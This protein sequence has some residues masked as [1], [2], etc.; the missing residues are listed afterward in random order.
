MKVYFAASECAP[1][2][3][4]GGLAD[5]VGGLP[6]A[7]A[8]LG[9]DTAIMLPKYESIKVI[10]VIN[11]INIIVNYDGKQESVKIYETR[12]P[13]TSIPVFLF[14]NQTYL[15]LGPVYSAVSAEGTS[16]DVDRFSF[17]SKAVIEYLKL[18]ANSPASPAGKQQPIAILHC[19]DWHTSWIPRLIKENGIEN[20]KTILTIHNLGRAYQGITDNTTLIK[21]DL[22][23]DVSKN[24]VNILQNG[25]ENADL[26]TTVSPTYA[27]EIQTEKMGEGLEAVLNDKKDKLSGIINGIDT[28]VWNPQTDGNLVANYSINNNWV[29]GKKINKIELLKQIGLVYEENVPLFGMV[30]RIAE[31]KGFDILIP[32]LDKI[33]SKH[34]IRVIILA[35]GDPRLQAKL[36][37][38]VEKYRTKIC[39]IKRFD[40]R[41]SH[42]IYAGSDFFPVPSKYEPCGLTQMLAMRYG[43]LP[44]VRKTGG[45]TDSV[46]DSE[47][48]FVFEEH[49]S[50]ALLAKMETA[51]E[52]YQ[53][54]L[55]GSRMD[56]SNDRVHLQG[57]R[58]DFS[59]VV[60][61]N[62]VEIAMQQD[63]SWT[64]SAKE[65][66]ILY[67]KVLMVR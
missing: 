50:Q 27:K 64:K 35:T 33:L 11:I 19:H 47:T 5:V 7:L 42:L 46:V 49:T 67:E 8:K 9:V 61:S 52:C 26:V 1:I 45:L 18:I 44:I 38:V 22:K 57:S 53:T 48:G 20:I 16:L 6:K 37:Q 30:S 54:H 63:F 51:I 14:E 29:N 25:I 2:V 23:D 36:E 56:S 15:S 58:M 43:A 65:Y 28:E 60:Y 39:L 41:L 62:M 17:L 4:V 12:L 55:Q 59:K 21:L 31:Q 40:D 66:L 13:E 3:K 32:A 24:T 10:N 34:E